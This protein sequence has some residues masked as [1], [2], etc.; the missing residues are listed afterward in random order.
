MRNTSPY[1]NLIIYLV[2]YFMCFDALKVLA[3]GKLFLLIQ[4]CDKEYK[5]ICKLI[6]QH[7]ILLKMVVVR[8]IFEKNY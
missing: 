4:S 8:L 5:Y 3:I 1:C 6:F 2:Y 7:K